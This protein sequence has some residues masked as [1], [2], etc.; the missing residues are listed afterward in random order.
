MKW[1]LA[2]QGQVLLILQALLTVLQCC[3]FQYHL[4]GVLRGNRPKE[5]ADSFSSYCV[6]TVLYRISCVS[7]L[8]SAKPINWLCLWMGE[9]KVS[10]ELWLLSW[11]APW[12]LKLLIANYCLWVFLSLKESIRSKC[13]L[14]THA[15]VRWTLI[16]CRSRKCTSQLSGNRD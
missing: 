12:D 14:T 13:F 9:H 7:I 3:D 10:N 8:S 1:G 11:S 6:S 2:C 15:T 16:P 5:R 4:S